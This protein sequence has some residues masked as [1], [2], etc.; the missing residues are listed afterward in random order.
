MRI[1]MFTNLYLP[2]VGGIQRSI[3]TFKEA[4]EARGHEVLVITPLVEDDPLDDLT[5]IEVPAIQHYNGSD[6]AVA[7]PLPSDVARRLE[8]FSPDLVHSHHPFLLGDRALRVASV[9]GCPLVFTYHTMWEHYLHYAPSESKAM[10]KFV[11]RMAAEYCNLCDHVIAPCESIAE[12]LRERGVEKPVTA[13]P[14]G[15]DTAGFGAGDGDATRRALDIPEDAFVAG[16]IGR[17]GPEKSLGFVSEGLARFCARHEQGHALVVGEGDAADEVRACFER[18][19]LRERLCM[20]GVLHDQELVNAY[21]ALDVFAFG[22]QSET[23]GL[24]LA[25]A[26]ASGCPVIAVDAPGARDIVR[27]GANGRLLAREDADSFAQAI[28]DVASCSREEYERLCSQARS[29]AA[30]LSTDRCASR[31]L[32][33]YEQLV[34]ANVTRDEE[35]DD[36]AW[37]RALRQLA[38]EWELWSGR[39]AAAGAAM[40]K[41]E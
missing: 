20:P 15:I 13:I 11:K 6:F 19:S 26:M 36:T 24:V 3:A 16:Y 10:Q 29:D 8:A 5:V 35:V 25:E 22:S 17:L 1:A 41:E 14:T 30:Q 27:D 33:L 21:H 4:F 7:L 31:A 37:A 34:A 18:A 12:V 23:Q 28:V 39:A 40:K 38:V 32:A 2:L 9:T